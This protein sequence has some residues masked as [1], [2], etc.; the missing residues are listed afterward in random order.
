MDLELG[1]RILAAAAFLHAF[2][3]FFLSLSL[4]QNPATH[5]CHKHPWSEMVGRSMHIT[6]SLLGEKGLKR[7]TEMSR[8]PNP[9]LPLYARQCGGDGTR[10]WRD[11]HAGLVLSPKQV[12]W[13][14]LLP[15]F[16]G[17]M[18][19]ELTTQKQTVWL[20]HGRRSWEFVHW[21]RSVF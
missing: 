18:H 3:N 8:N 2:S 6:A 20:Q 21:R 10:A 17:P 12:E 4:L 16:G 11:K 9:Q 1:S 13:S 14:S 7:S 19:R 5:A 15:C